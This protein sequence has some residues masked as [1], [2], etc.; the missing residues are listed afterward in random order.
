M[1]HT[2]GDKLK[3]KNIIISVHEKVGTKSPIVQ[4]SKKKKV[5]RLKKEHAW[6]MDKSLEMHEVIK[7]NSNSLQEN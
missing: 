6:K 5:S 7:P 4:K 2:Q 1:C 3:I